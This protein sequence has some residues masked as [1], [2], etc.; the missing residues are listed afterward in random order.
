MK[1]NKSALVHAEFVTGAIT[2]LL[3]SGS[4]LEVPFLPCIV[5]PLSVSVNSSGKER[6][7]LD[8][9]NLNNYVWKEHFKF[10][11]WKVA[12]DF[13]L[14]DGFMYKFD[15][16]SAYHHIDICT[17]QQTFLG[18]SW[19]YNGIHKYFVFT[20]LPFGL[21]SAPFIFTKCLRC[22]VKLAR[23]NGIRLVVFL[24]DG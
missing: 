3:T 13:L 20:V 6:L 2:D 1:N 5:S 11:D 10:E 16:T 9:S 22:I 14:K 21:T 18:F 8:L 7:I 12:F 23:E 17:S 4:V 24:D 15:I 19:N